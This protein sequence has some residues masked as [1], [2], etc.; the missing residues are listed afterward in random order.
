MYSL[1]QSLFLE[2]YETNRLK[3]WNIIFFLWQIR[4]LFSLST[5]IIILDL[6]FYVIP[7]E[8]I[9]I[10]SAYLFYLLSRKTIFVTSFHSSVREDPSSKGSPLTG[11][12]FFPGIKFFNFRADKYWFVRW[13]IL[14]GLP[15]LCLYPFTLSLGNIQNCWYSIKT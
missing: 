2:S 6:N 1:K 3:D 13:N 9:Y 12:K 5:S 4:F 11:R 10:Y 14:T 7:H 15:R 8:Y